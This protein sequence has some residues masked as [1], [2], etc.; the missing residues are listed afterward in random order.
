MSTAVFGATGAVGSALARR[1]LAR[2]STPW[3][4]GRS[5]P[6]LEALSSELGGAPFTVVDVA[7]A[8]TIGPAL[9]DQACL[10]Y[11]SPSPRDYAASRMPSSD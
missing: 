2:G 1:L 11:T 6:K 4:I 8:S 3:L 7:D 9:K 10:L 5:Q